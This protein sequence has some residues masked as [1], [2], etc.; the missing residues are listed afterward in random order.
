MSWLAQGLWRVAAGTSLLLACVLVGLWNQDAWLALISRV[1]HRLAATSTS[2]YVLVMSK[3]A[4][5]VLVFIGLQA[6]AH[7]DPVVVYQRF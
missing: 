2:L 1:E 3:T 6:M 4:V 5:L 7:P